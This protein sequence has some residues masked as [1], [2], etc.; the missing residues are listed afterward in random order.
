[1]ITRPTTAQLLEVVR[2]HLNEGVAPAVS[3]PQVATTLAMVDHI[4]HTLAVRADH[5]L[6]W[7]TDEMASIDAVGEQIAVSGLPGAPAV[8]EALAAFRAGRTSSL[9]A[10]D[11]T[12]DY[13]RATEVLSRAVEATLAEPGA[14]RDAVSALLDE[15]LAHEVD[16]IGEFQL[17]GRG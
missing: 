15:R 5:E 7:M 14:W 10:A 13:Q 17:V 12:E 4:L 2:R 9:H 16:V 1:M 6:G 8:R 11:V 3:D